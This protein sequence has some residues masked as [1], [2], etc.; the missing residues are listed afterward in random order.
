M[1]AAKQVLLNHG[2]DF[3]KDYLSL[4][5]GISKLVI[6]QASATSSI[7]NNEKQVVVGGNDLRLI[8]RLLKIE[9]SIDSL[10]NKTNRIKKYLNEKISV[11]T[12]GD[13]NEAIMDFGSTVCKP[14]KFLCQSCIFSLE[15]Q[16]YLSNTVKNYPIKSHKIKSVRKK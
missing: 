15:C 8:S 5:N 13:F 9:E 10:N 12:P 6:I 1:K 3:P 7:C 2:G 14:K 4:L 11:E 16:A